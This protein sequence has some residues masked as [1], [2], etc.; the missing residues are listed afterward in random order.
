VEDGRSTR[1]L[2]VQCSFNWPAPA[3]LNLF[4]H[5]TGRR[6]DGYHLL[7]TVF[8]FLSLND[9][10]SF[11]L[12]DDGVIARANSLVGILPEQDLTVRAARALQQASGCRRGVTIRLD[13]RLPMG[14]GVGGGSSDA[15]TVLVALNRLWGCEL[16]PNELMSLGLSLGADVPVFINGCAAFAEGIGERLQPLPLPEP[17]FLVIK[18]PVEIATAEVFAA[19]ELTRNCPPIT[20]P[21]FLS[22]GGVNVCEPVV[23]RRYPEVAKALD[24]LSDYAAARLTGTGSCVFAAFEARESAD[25]VRRLLPIGW[26]GF[27]AQGLN[28][29]PLLVRLAAESTVT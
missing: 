19:P 25:R 14:G 9:E 22:R 23:R 21:D 26:Q 10:L 6:A 13:K 17:W 2:V 28:R 20:I 12:R 7:Q 4:L 24:W 11:E 3:K 5:I 15:A 18:P 27:L 29:S 1:I 8:Q 16:S